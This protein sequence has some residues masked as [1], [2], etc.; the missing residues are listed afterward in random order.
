M[1]F[2]KPNLIRD[3]NGA[4]TRKHFT[5]NA[6][7]TTVVPR[8]EARTNVTSH[9]G[10]EI[11]KRDAYQFGIYDCPPPLHEK[12]AIALRVMIFSGEIGITM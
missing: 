11:S 8:N 4:K 5:R 2:L 12:C 6:A 1:H 3:I 9:T 10:F 7:K